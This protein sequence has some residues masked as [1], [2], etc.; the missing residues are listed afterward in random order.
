MALALILSISLCAPAYATEVQEENDSEY[1]I[2]IAVNSQEEYDYIVAELEAH[3]VRANQLWQ[4]SLLE[5]RFPENKTSL[6]ELNYHSQ[7]Q[8]E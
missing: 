3:N 5:F 2:L 6:L 1:A 4:Q 7:S 8:T